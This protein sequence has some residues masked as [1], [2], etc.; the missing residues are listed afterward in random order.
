MHARTTVPELSAAYRTAVRH[1][2]VT[3]PKQAPRTSSLK[4]LT[5]R[6]VNQARD[7]IRATG[8]VTRPSS[9][10][11]TVAPQPPL[12]LEFHGRRRLCGV[13]PSDT[14]AASDGHNDEGSGHGTE[15]ATGEC[16]LRMI[17]NYNTP[18]QGAMPS[19]KRRGAS[20]SSSKSYCESLTDRRYKV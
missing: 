9:G 16:R 14:T 19:P 7:F 18:V 17:T 10:D 3:G 2:F 11:G 20:Y 13:A 15:R 5:W 1:A 8:S 4:L 12:D 6:Q